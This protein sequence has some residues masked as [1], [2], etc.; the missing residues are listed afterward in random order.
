M[1]RTFQRIGRSWNTSVL[2]TKNQYFFMDLP[3]L[4]KLDEKAL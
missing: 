4:H 1:L 3:P 2:V